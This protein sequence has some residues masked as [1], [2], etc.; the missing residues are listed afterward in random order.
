MSSGHYR[1][2]LGSKPLPSLQ[3]PTSV[4]TR[5]HN[6]GT[7]QFLL[8]P[9]GWSPAAWRAWALTAKGT[10]NTFVHRL[11]PAAVC[12]PPKSSGQLEPYPACEKQ[13]RSDEQKQ[14][15]Y[16]LVT[17]RT[18][19]H[20]MAWPL[21]TSPQAKGQPWEGGLGPELPPTVIGKNGTLALW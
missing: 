2:L 15:H 8:L 18:A 12:S 1:E 11:H 3:T 17:A 14:G 21:P 6:I 9:Y 4:K 16:V 13:G 19:G 5:S 7:P 10:P 20:K